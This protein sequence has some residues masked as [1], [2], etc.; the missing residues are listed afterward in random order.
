MQI[1]LTQEYQPYN[2]EDLIVYRSTRLIFKTLLYT[3]QFLIF[4]IT[5]LSV[6]FE[7]LKI[8][9]ITILNTFIF[10][11]P[12]TEGQWQ[13]GI[14]KSRYILFLSFFKILQSQS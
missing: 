12:R 8:L 9:V 4:F 7:K 5:A 1:E 6:F 10:M 13:S 3:L 2:I 14:L 11:W